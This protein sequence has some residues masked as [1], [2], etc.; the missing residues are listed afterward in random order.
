M[1]RRH[2]VE[3]MAG[4]N[5]DEPRVTFAGLV[6]DR[7]YAFVD[8][9]N[10]PNFPPMTGRQAP[11]LI[12]F[13]PQFLNPPSVV[14]ENPTSERHGAEAMTPEGERFEVSDPRFKEHLEQRS[15]RS[16]RLRFSGRSMNDSRPVSFFGRSRKRRA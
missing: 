11:D 3:S 13:R 10:R 9:G 12:L 14:E 15:G 2:P 8:G 6:G 16:L 5:L 7:V 4:E 1:L